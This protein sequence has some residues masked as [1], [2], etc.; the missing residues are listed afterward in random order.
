MVFWDVLICSKRPW[1]Y[2]P[3]DDPRFQDQ[4]KDQSRKRKWDLPDRIV[5]EKLAE[6]DGKTIDSMHEKEYLSKMA[7]HQQYKQ[8]PKIKFESIADLKEK[9]FEDI[10]TSTGEQILYKLGDYN[11]STGMRF[12]AFI[13]KSNAELIAL[14]TMLALD[15]TFD[16]CCFSI[17][18]HEG[19]Y[20]SLGAK[21]VPKSKKIK[22]VQRCQGSPI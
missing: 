6:L 20:R 14:T 12:I 4:I 18:V 5:A 8:R 16:V 10:R 11:V 2:N 21:L 15:S 22:V 17:G 3:S 19:L 7:R 9:D 1:V 13:P